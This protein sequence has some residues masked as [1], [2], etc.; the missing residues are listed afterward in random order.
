MTRSRGKRRAPNVGR[1][2]W[3]GSS[4][5]CR[6]SAPPASPRNQNYSCSNQRPCRP[7]PMCRRPR[8]VRCSRW[9][10]DLGWAGSSSSCRPSP[11]PASPRW[12]TQRPC[13]PS[14]MCTRPP[15]GWGFRRSGWAWAGSS[16]PCRPS[17][18]PALRRR[19][20]R[21][22]KPSLTCTRPPAVGCR[23]RSGG[24]G[25]NVQLVPF[26]P[27]ASVCVP[28]E[29]PLGRERPTAVH[30]EP[31]LHDTPWR[32]LW[33]LPGAFGVP[34]IVQLVPPTAPPGLE[35]RWDR[36]LFICVADGGA[37]GRRSARDAEED[38]GDRAARG[39]RRLDRPVEPSRSLSQGCHRRGRERVVI[40]RRISG[41]GAEGAVRTGAEDLAPSL[42]EPRTPTG[43]GYSYLG[44]SP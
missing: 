13:R 41:R 7:S 31:E 20:P 34:W 16:S 42:G 3:A 35:H 29:P 6:P 8:A 38:G 39:G 32:P 24:V 44:P 4:S 12:R 9:D 33:A 30:A 28:L 43:R 25:W 14:P 21:R 27:S 18:P 1:S 10:W 26:Q 23:P 40:R 36:E 11:P 22:C 15:R 19:S 2:V 5:W 37:R 17:A